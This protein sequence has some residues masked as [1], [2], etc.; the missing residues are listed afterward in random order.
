MSATPYLRRYLK[1]DYFNIERR[2]YDLK[3]FNNWPDP[4]VIGNLL[5]SG[6]SYTGVETETE[7][8]IF[9][10]GVRPVWKGVCECWVVSSG[11]VPKYKI[12]FHKSACSILGE[13]KVYYNA[14]RMQTVIHSEHT[15]S[16][17]WVEALGFNW[18]GILRKYIDGEDYFRYAWL[19][20]A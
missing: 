8:I 19:K 9:C 12:F 14:V 13:A 6:I 16:Q 5:G 11:L 1:D 7:K 2:F 3:T 18:E 4:K 20:T 15:T 17:R 10:M